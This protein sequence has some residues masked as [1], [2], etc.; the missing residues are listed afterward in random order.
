MEIS[1]FKTKT[2]GQ[3][4]ARRMNELLE[5]QQVTERITALRSERA[6]ANKLFF[7]ESSTS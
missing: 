1:R 4:V 7:A 2:G 3:I 5:C 6:L